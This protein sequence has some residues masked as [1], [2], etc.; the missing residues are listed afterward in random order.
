[1]EQRLIS[2]GILN[3]THMQWIQWRGYER[4]MRRYPITN[5]IPIT[6]L[7]HQKWC[8][9]EKLSEWNDNMGSTCLRC[10]LE[11]ETI[12]HIFQCRSTDAK[13]VHLNAL[14][15]LR[16]DLK[17]A[18]TIPLVADHIVNVLKEH[19][20][21]YHVEVRGNGFYSD[22]IQEMAKK[23][24]SKQR[25]LGPG[26]ICKGFLITEWEA[27][28]NICSNNNTTVSS[29]IEWSSK[30]TQALW[31][32]SKAVWDGRCDAINKKNPS[33]NLRLKSAELLKVI[34]ADVNFLRESMSDYD[35]AQLLHN[36]DTKKSKAQDGTLYKWLQ[37]LRH[38]KEELARRKRHNQ[39]RQP[40][41][42]SIRRWCR[43]ENST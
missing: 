8:T 25:E 24:E 23:V 42:Q 21:Q 12:D 11:I 41:A 14:T 28:Q 40:R 18:Q 6:K 38:R 34:E 32:Y 43:L 5:K 39:I 31:T 15:K 13:T 10:Q 17:R 2:K 20:L 29:N 30:T 1:M 33:T 9:K 26:A 4:A 16:E 35:T 27:L 22:Q 19:R 36:I 3:A 37:M 7:I